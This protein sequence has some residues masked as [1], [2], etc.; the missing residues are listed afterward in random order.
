[1]IHTYGRAWIELHS[2]LDQ[3]SWR[4]SR[5]VVAAFLLSASAQRSLVA[6]SRGSGCVI[7]STPPLLWFL[8]CSKCVFCCLLFQICWKTVCNI[9]LIPIGSI[10]R[11]KQILPATLGY[12]N[13]EIR[14]GNQSDSGKVVDF[15]G[16][17]LNMLNP[18]L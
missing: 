8:R 11:I 17:S 13:P 4:W 6:H 14:T 9:F 10:G 2:L 18:Y 12:T 5:A 15:E 16:S 1:M 3:R 7:D